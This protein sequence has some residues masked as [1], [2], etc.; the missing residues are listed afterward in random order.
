MIMKHVRG[1]RAFD[2]ELKRGLMTEEEVR[3]LTK[4]VMTISTLDAKRDKYPWR[5]RPSYAFDALYVETA[6]LYRDKLFPSFNHHLA[7]DASISAMSELFEE[8]EHLG[9]TLIP[10]PYAQLNRVVA[11]VFLILLPFGTGT[12]LGHFNVLF[13]SIVYTIY[14]TLDACAWP[15]RTV[16]RGAHGALRRVVIWARD[17]G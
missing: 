10:L 14:F 16:K 13:C 11:V 4:E 17:D 6:R 15:D 3:W 5:N 1:D 12:T 7:V 9:Q 2:E 8:V